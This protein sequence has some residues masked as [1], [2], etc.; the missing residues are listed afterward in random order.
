MNKIFKT[1]KL[2]ASIIMVLAILVAIN[3]GAYHI[4]KRWDLTANQLYS[5]SDV[6][7]TT[8]KNLDKEVEI[9]VLFGPEMPAQYLNLQQAVNDILAEYAS[10]SRNIQIKA[11][12]PEKIA[13]RA[14]E[15][16]LPR[17]QFNTL[18]K[19]KLEVLNGYLGL[20]LQYEGKTEII[21]VVQDTSN[22][23]Y[24][25]TSL[26]KK[27]T[28]SELPTI[29]WVQSHG[30]LDINKQ[31]QAAYQ[32]LAKLYTI[33]TV[34]LSTIEP[35]DPQ[36]KTL[37][38][39]G[40]KSA[41]EE[42]A[43]QKIN[44]Y[45]MQGKTALLLE[46][47]I[48]LGNNLSYHA[49][50]NNL[51]QLLAQYGLKVNEQLVLDKVNAVA[52]FNQGY[53]TF[54]IN[55]PF[56]PKLANASFAQDVP[57]VAKLEGIVLPWTTSLSVTDQ[58][59]ASTKV[60]YL[61]KT[62]NQAWTKSGD[63]NL[64]PNQNLYGNEAL[65][66]YYVAVKLSGLTNSTTQQTSADAQLIVVADSDF[67]QDQILQIYPQNL[68]LF[69]NLVDNLALDSDL[70]TIRAKE[71]IDR[72]IKDISAT[73]KRWLRYGNVFGLTIL[74]IILGLARYYWRRKSNHFSL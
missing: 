34:D 66:Q 38:I 30:A 57:A 53:V 49:T 37:I 15:L 72:P 6:S 5:L 68:T 28:S 13:K 20:A 47:K 58:L 69:Q 60:D 70:A 43:L 55:Y 3:F 1:S 45:L 67:M 73:H 59:P 46:E 65:Q 16:K 56:W 26:I 9:E 21:P 52:P 29:G 48:G 4:F 23:E 25:I 41:M 11:V 8:V 31:T 24:Q 14:E 19:D 44:D 62:S 36:I 27:L 33:K 35:I 17:V 51:D 39:P 50:A 22:L 71:M 64:M 63:Y 18:Q 7:Q 40:L 10:Y 54:N 61:A 12:E 32:A 42:P 2:S 74:V